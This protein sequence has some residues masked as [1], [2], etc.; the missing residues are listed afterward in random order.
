MAMRL[1][2]TA[3]MPPPMAMPP[4]TSSQP[5]KPAGGLEASVVSTAMVM[6]TMPNRLPWREVTGLESP[7]SARMKS[8]PETR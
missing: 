1:A 4:I 6:P 2:I 5:P 3:P 7:R 8:T